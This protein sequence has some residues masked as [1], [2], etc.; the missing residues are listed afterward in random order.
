MTSLKKLG[1]FTVN[2]EKVIQP[3]ILYK[4]TFINQY[5]LKPSIDCEDEDDSVTETT[6]MLNED[7]DEEIIID[8]PISKDVSFVRPRKAMSR[9]EYW[10]R[11]GLQES[12]GKSF[13]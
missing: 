12:C 6:V 8:E 2:T 10:A 9:I 11:G 13:P 7:R 4:S 1:S 3:M 5:L